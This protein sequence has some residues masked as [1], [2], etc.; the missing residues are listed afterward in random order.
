MLADKL[1]VVLEVA[2]VVVGALSGGIHAAKRNADIV[3]IFVLALATAVGGGMLRDILIGAGPPLAL[4]HPSYLIVVAVAALVTLVLADWLAHMNRLLEPLDAL[5]LGLWTVIGVERAAAHHLPV[6]SA[7]FLGTVTA[8]G[9]GVARDLLSGERPALL[10]KGELYVT[11]A[12]LAAVVGAL[13]NHVP[14][15]PPVVGELLTIV[16]AFAVRM[17]AVRWHLTTPTPADLPRW[18]RGRRSKPPAA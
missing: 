7:I 15:A 5:L 10:H 1:P 12:F 18:W 11:A 16:V 2:A 9:G 6:T 8:T 17:A 3:G 14:G 13:S 4:V